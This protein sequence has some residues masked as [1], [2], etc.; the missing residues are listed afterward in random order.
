MV[1][2]EATRCIRSSYCHQGWCR[3]STKMRAR[4]T[5]DI[6]LYGR[7]G[8]LTC[9]EEDCI[10]FLQRN[11]KFYLAFENCNCEDYITEKFFVTGL[12]NGLVPVVM[13][14]TKSDYERR[15]PPHSFIHVDDF[16]SPEELANYLLQ[17]DGDEDLYQKYFDWRRNPE[18]V[19]TLTS[20]NQ[21]DF[22]CR[23]CG[24]LYYA[25]FVPPQPWPN[26]ETRFADVSPCQHN[27]H[28]TANNLYASALIIIHLIL[29]I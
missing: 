23:V 5:R 25:D 9:P 6:D 12:Y 28:S 14:A 3:Y 10:Q 20:R 27:S 17:L 13:G 29:H 21:E 15:A 24:M 2:G 19:W 7:C 16:G 22:F 1:T 4:V 26:R 8:T 18:T 11:Y